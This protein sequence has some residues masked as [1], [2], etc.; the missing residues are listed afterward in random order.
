MTATST[1]TWNGLSEGEVAKR[2]GLPGVTLFAEVDS[3]QDVAHG[4][5]EKGAPAGS[6]VVADA[7]R[8]GRG[9]QGRSWSSR[10]GQGVWCTIIERPRDT[11]ALEVLS[12]RIGLRLASA[13]DE[14]AGQRV[15]LKWPNDLLLREGKL[16]GVLV[17]ARWSGAAIAWV[18]VGV[19]VNVAHP[20]VDGGAALLP[21]VQ[22]I[23]VLHAVVDAVRGAAAC[24]G[25][26]TA[27]E[28]ERFRDRDALAGQRILSPAAGVVQGIDASGALLVR[29]DGGVSAHRSGT[30]QLENG[31]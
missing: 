13:L 27:G 19:G 2:L 25:P 18:A 17:E 30:V 31:S 6:L 1:V 29:D 26:L 21:G 16:A 24:I 4:L 9:R 3:T 15:R 23:D 7:Q 14:F 28:I 11:S 20:G 8:A 12:L 22:R 5:A 10:P